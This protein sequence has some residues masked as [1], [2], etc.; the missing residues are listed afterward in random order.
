MV[1]KGHFSWDAFLNVWKH[2]L[3]AGDGSVGARSI[4]TA[5][6]SLKHE[7]F[8]QMVP[9]FQ[10]SIQLAA[11]RMQCSLRET[12]EKLF[13]ASCLSRTRRVLPS[14]SLHISVFHACTLCPKVASVSSGTKASATLWKNQKGPVC[15]CCFMHAHHFQNKSGFSKFRHKSFGY[16][17]EKSERPCLFVVFF[18]NVR[19]WNFWETICSSGT[20]YWF[21]WFTGT[22]TVQL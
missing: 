21:W 22:K 3:F 15:C 6:R 4:D 7:T 5:I 9:W 13:F 18:I 8:S 11:L 20:P 17:L 1:T 19:I 2:L 14:A 12:S 16:S 10:R